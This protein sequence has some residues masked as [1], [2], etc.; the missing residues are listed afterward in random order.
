MSPIESALLQSAIEISTVMKWV[1]LAVAVIFAL[2]AAFIYASRAQDKLEREM[3][4]EAD[5]ADYDEQFATASTLNT[6]GFV[7]RDLK[8]AIA[9]AYVQETCNAHPIAESLDT[10]ILAAVSRTYMLGV[11]DGQIQS[12]QTRV[13]G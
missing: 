13:C 10:A 5:G 6:L 7:R 8:E 12:C 1:C 11:S 3:S 4:A 2:I 9:A